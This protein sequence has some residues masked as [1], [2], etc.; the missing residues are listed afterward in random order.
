M[1]DAPQNEAPQ[2]LETKDAQ[3]VAGGDGQ[4]VIGY[5]QAGAPIATRTGS[6]LTDD[7]RDASSGDGPAYGIT[8]ASGGTTTQNALGSTEKAATT[9]P[10]KRAAAAK[11]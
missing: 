5:R 4:S 9:T 2:G 10:A 6:Q 8:T 1:A 7:E 3:L 11:G